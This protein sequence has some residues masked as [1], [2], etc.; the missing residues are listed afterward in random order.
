M[1][2]S[3]LRRDARN[4]FDLDPELRAWLCNRGNGEQLRRY[5]AWWGIVISHGSFSNWM[6]GRPV[7]RRLAM[8][9]S[10]A[11]RM[12]RQRGLLPAGAT[13]RQNPVSQ[14]VRAQ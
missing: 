5:L 12:L 6:R 7:S 8:A 2:E 3:R 14:P 11:V 4:E 13:Q 1:S 10:P 9:M